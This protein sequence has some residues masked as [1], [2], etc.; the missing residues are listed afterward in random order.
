MN[1]RHTMNHIASW[2]RMK[3]K[4]IIINILSQGK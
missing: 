1:V 2:G 3:E 4:R